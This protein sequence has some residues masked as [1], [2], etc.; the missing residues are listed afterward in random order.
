[1][2]GSAQRHGIEKDVK[3]L[4]EGKKKA[5]IFPQQCQKFLIFPDLPQVR[6]ANEHLI[7]TSG[8]C[9]G[10]LLEALNECLN[11]AQ[12]LPRSYVNSGVSGDEKVL[13]NSR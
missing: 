9:K 10:R 3:S 1:M 8:V 12:A 11:P 2:Y 13:Q 7:R 6:K 4:M 5:N